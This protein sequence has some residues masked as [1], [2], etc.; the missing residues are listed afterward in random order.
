MKSYEVLPC[1]PRPHLANSAAEAVDLF[2]KETAFCAVRVADVVL[3]PCR[4]ATFDLETIQTTLTLGQLAQTPFFVV[5]HAVPPRS[6]I[7]R[8][9]AEGLTAQGTSVA[10][11]MLATA[12]APARSPLAL[13]GAAC[14]L[15]P[16]AVPR[17]QQQFDVFRTPSWRSH[18]RAA[19]RIAPSFDFSDTQICWATYH[20]SYH[21][22]EA[23]RLL[24]PAL[25]S[26]A[27]SGG[28]SL[29]HGGDCLHGFVHLG[30]GFLVC[31]ALP[32]VRCQMVDP[33]FFDEIGRAGSSR[34]RQPK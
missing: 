6:G 3:I 19:K 28:S 25:C 1:S 4:P 34:W 7:G 18:L 29:A 17:W 27:S 10:P 14:S 16:P 24:R 21:R 11:V 26:A 23:T 30:G 2:A 31:R 5:L 13:G 22:D 33:F 9:A 12:M 20:A 8:E 32:R 15:V